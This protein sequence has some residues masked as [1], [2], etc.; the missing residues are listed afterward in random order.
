MSRATYVTYALMASSSGAKNPSVQIPEYGCRVLSARSRGGTRQ[1]ILIDD[2]IYEMLPNVCTWHILNVGYAHD[3]NKSTYLHRLVWALSGNPPPQPGQSIDHINWI[4][5]DNR[6][7]NLRLATQSEQNNNRN[8]RKDKVFMPTALQATLA[9]RGYTTPHLP[10]YVRYEEKRDRFT[11]WGHPKFDALK[12][13]SRE[14]LPP[15]NGTRSSK[16]TMEHKLHDC[17]TNYVR[18][19]QM[20]EDTGAFR[21]RRTTLLKEA[22]TIASIASAMDPDLYPTF[23]VDEYH[24]L[25]YEMELATKLLAVL[26]PP[27][28]SDAKGAPKRIGQTVISDDVCRVSGCNGGGVLYDAMYAPVLGQFSWSATESRIKIPRSPTA[29]NNA[30][31]SLG[32]GAIPPNLVDQKVQVAQFVVEVLLGR[33]VPEGHVV[34]PI[35]HVRADVR[36]ANLAIAEGEGKNFKTPMSTRWPEELVQA[37]GEVIPRGLHVSADVRG[38]GWILSFDCAVK[39]AKRKLLPVARSAGDVADRV[40]EYEAIVEK[41]WPLQSP[42]RRLGTPLDPRAVEALLKDWK[43]ANAYYVEMAISCKV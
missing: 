6:V 2:H 27:P 12:S 15:C 23:D 39:N 24:C 13:L 35:N 20:H 22:M 43:T 3:T 29:L 11:F 42:F 34:V 1:S 7:A 5:T 36:V 10:K 21:D 8:I 38:G 28:S 37:M 30:L 40:A 41:D 33:S 19:L 31:A 16:C 26:R 14:D 4:K 18:V 32:L 25:D 9:E 17:L